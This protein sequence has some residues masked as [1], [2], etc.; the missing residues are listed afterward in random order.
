MAILFHCP[1][2]APA[3]GVARVSVEPE[4]CQL[5]VPPDDAPVALGRCPHCDGFVRRSLAGVHPDTLRAWRD[6]DYVQ[7]APAFSE[8]EARRYQDV[9]T[10]AVSAGT[11]D[12]AVARWLAELVPADR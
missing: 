4:W 12:A 1:E 7:D 11:F 10:D 3:D 8:F 6:D 9:D 5:M 2:C